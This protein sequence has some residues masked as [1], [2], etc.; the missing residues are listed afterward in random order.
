MLVD[1]HL[2]FRDAL[3]S[4]VKRDGRFKIVSEASDGASALENLKQSIPDIILMDIQMPGMGGI[5]ATRRILS[6]Y[7]DVKVI[8]ITVAVGEAII[9]SAMAPSLLTE[10]AALAQNQPGGDPTAIQ[11]DNG[12][13]GTAA[14]ADLIIP[15]P[16]TDSNLLTPREYQVLE[17]VALGLANKEISVRLV[18]SENT[19]RSHLRSILDKLHM[20]NRVQA[21]LWLQEQKSASS[22]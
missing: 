5:E 20:N 16:Q 10:F 1:D 2:L 14:E 4:L 18:I 11:K 3:A 13:A 22:K 15:T 21:A 6:A 17:L 19:V 7:P 9:P 12:Q 8:M